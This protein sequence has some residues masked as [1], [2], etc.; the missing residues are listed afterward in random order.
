MR[1]FIIIAGSILAVIAAAIL[2]ISQKPR[3][4][5]VSNTLEIFSWW[6]AAGEKEGLLDLYDLFNQKY[7]DVEIVTAT[8]VGGS[9]YNARPVLETLIKGGSPPDAVQ[10]LAGPGLVQ[11]WVKPGYL[12]PLT[13]LYKENNWL[14]VFPKE[15]LDKVSYKGEIY[16]VPLNIHRGNL[17]WYNKHIFKKFDLQPPKTL[18][19]FFSTCESLADKGVTPLAVGD[20]NNWPTNHLLE[21]IIISVLGADGYRG[22]WT[23]DSKWNTPEM[24]HSLQLF[25]DAFKYVNT[26]HA[27][28]TWD[29]GVQYVI[30]GQ[31]AMVIIGDFAEAYF[32][33]KGSIPDEDF[34]WTLFP[35]T[36]S[37]F[38]MFS[39]NFV[40]PKDAQHRENTIRWLEL[41][42]SKEGQD[43]FNPKKGSIPARIDCDESNYDIYLRSSIKDLKSSI[44]VGSYTHGATVTTEWQKEITRIT[45]SLLID[46]NSKRA[47]EELQTAAYQFTIAP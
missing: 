39:D 17:I 9:G 34:G 14:D 27:A 47:M 1:K 5:T 11:T 36:E 37:V 23:G 15:V 6:T 31:C 44:I 2:I 45:G 16:A 32:K 24:E 42:G 3:P 41:L 29:E 7:P 28:L 4:K 10:V 30:D 38:V 20:L 33:A 13:F 40:L 35:G 19:E 46:R 22:L 25:L 12:E 18:A 26:D 8:I 43:T 21:C